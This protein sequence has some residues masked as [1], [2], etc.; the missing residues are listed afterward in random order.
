MPAD[1]RARIALAAGLLIAAAPGSVGSAMAGAARY[2][3]PKPAVWAE[4]G[5][6][7][8]ACASDGGCTA[9]SISNLAEESEV[10]HGVEESEVSHE[11]RDMLSVGMPAGPGARPALTYRTVLV[12][13]GD[14]RPDGL[15]FT[16]YGSDGSILPD[17][18]LPGDVGS[19]GVASPA[20]ERGSATF[21]DLALKASAVGF[22]VRGMAPAGTVNLDGFRQTLEHLDREQ[23][24]AGGPS[25]LV[26]RGNSPD[27]AHARRRL[28]PVQAVA[29]SEAPEPSLAAFPPWQEESGCIQPEPNAFQTLSGDAL[30]AAFRIDGGKEL[31]Q[32]VCGMGAYQSAYRFFVRR[33]RGR[34]IEAP[35]VQPAGPDRIGTEWPPV[36]F[37][38]VALPEQ[39]RFDTFYKLR[40]AGDCG[41]VDTW[42]WDGRA[43][44]L[45]ERRLM[46]TCADLSTI[47]WPVM[48]QV[49]ILPPRGAANTGR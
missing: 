22:G 36:L 2:D 4:Y 40:G 48:H 41:M 29:F 7:T 38:P 14:P 25:A 28:A 43:L 10:S 26:L 1:A 44:V 39:G 31:I 49:E 16:F 45:A 46:R 24:R 21:M 30:A 9:L 6:W 8:L 32:R 37:N 47:H 20:G 12:I 23:G 11:P 15:V 5:A 34:L 17:G 35:L 33:G 13:D 19:D 42:V 18:I 27:R 3:T